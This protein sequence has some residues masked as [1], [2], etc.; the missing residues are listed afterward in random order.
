VETDSPDEKFM[1]PAHLRKGIPRFYKILELEDGTDSIEKV[2]EVT[3]K[4]IS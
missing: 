3:L 4:W 2:L 1:K